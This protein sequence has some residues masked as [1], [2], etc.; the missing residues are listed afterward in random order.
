[1]QKILVILFWV[2][3]PFGLSSAWA[4]SSGKKT[5]SSPRTQSAQKCDFTFKKLKLC[6]TVQWTVPPKKVEMISKEDVAQLVLT[7]SPK[8]GEDLDVTVVATM[9]S[10]GHG[11]ERIRVVKIASEGVAADS[12]RYQV[13]NIYLSMPGEWQFEVK[14]KKAGQLVDRAVW[15][16]TL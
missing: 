11:T 3:L 2:M 5:V 6:G 12:S 15:T 9:P 13:E 14:L 1:M 10:M 7:V 8:Q 16:Y 4:K